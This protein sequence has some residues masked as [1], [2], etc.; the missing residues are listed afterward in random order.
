[1]GKLLVTVRFRI[2]RVKHRHTA[3]FD[4]VTVM[5]ISPC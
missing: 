2:I 1:M 5:I 3:V 4:V